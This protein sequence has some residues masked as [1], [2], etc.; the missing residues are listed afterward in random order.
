MRRAPAYKTNTDHTEDPPL[1]LKKAS[2]LAVFVIGVIAFFA[3]DLGQYFS[4][5]YIKQSQQRSI[6]RGACNRNMG[7]WRQSLGHP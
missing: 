3:F 6:E 1:N 4:L 5:A 2:L 7:I